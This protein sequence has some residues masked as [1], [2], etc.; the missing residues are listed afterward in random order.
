MDTRK[1]IN[2]PKTKSK[3]VPSAT[4]TAPIV[5][6]SASSPASFFGERRIPQDILNHMALFAFPNAP[7]GDAEFLKHALYNEELRHRY[8]ARFDAIFPAFANQFF[9][10]II[11][12]EQA[13]AEAMIQKFPGLLLLTGT[14]T[15]YSGRQING[16]ALGMAL[17]A[18]DVRFH[19]NE[20]CMVEM[21]HKCLKRLPNGEEIIVKQTREQFPDGW[22]RVE[23]ARV[24]SDHEA[25]KK[26]FTAIAKSQTSDDCEVAI[27]T[28]RDYL[29]RENKGKG[30]I[31]TGKH[32]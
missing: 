13:E 5:T 25:L 24:K 29:D 3:N 2:N 6:Y 27:G 9:L 30:V 19:L 20:E 1:T 31:M 18:E 32:F 22:E 16:S 8:Q 10:H 12:G 17:G 4:Q 14:V 23:A 11:H 7:E 26:V 15:D 28:F 21:I